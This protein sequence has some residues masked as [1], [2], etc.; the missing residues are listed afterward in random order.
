[1]NKATKLM[2]VLVGVLVVCMAAYLGLRWWNGT[3][4][5]RAVDDKTYLAQLE[6]IT[7][8]TWQ[9]SGETLS[10]EKDEEGVWRDASDADFPLD[11]SYLTALETTLSQLSAVKVISDPE[12]D[13]SYGL[14]A[15]ELTLTASTSVGETWEV[16][17]GSEVDGNYY[18]RPAG[19]SQVYTIAAALMNQTEYGLMEMIDLDTIPTVTESSVESVEITAGG[20][21]TLFTK[22]TVTSTDGEGN[23]T[24]TYAWSRNGEALYSEDG[25]LADGVDALAGLSFTSC[26]YWKPSGDTLTA[27]GLDDTA[28]RITITYEGGSYVLL[29]GG[30]DENGYYY[31]QL[32]GS[33]QVNLMYAATPDSLLRL[34]TAQTQA[35]A[36][37]A[38]QAEET[39][40]ETAEES[41]TGTDAAASETPAETDSGAE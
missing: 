41:A 28:T 5:D 14:D 27:C 39:E 26:A 13:A 20:V 36:D 6:D 31:A 32:E 10:F 11:Q 8:L 4:E 16:T 30:T 17:V 21:T 7:S 3:A 12:E 35:E 23:E 33:Q 19:D 34:L 24:T 22:E 29:L 9:R 1:M 25:N 2:Y 37:A 18:A 15:P 40:S 38:A